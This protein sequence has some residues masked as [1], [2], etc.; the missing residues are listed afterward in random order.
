MLA[1]EAAIVIG[2][3][4]AVAVAGIALL[5]FVLD[6]DPEFG[7]LLVGLVQATIVMIGAIITR[8]QVYSADTVEKMFADKEV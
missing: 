8:G 4:D 5:V 6:W 7:V 1:K 3:I 2:A